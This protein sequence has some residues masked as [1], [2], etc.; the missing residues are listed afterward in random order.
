MSFMSIFPSSF[1]SSQGSYPPEP[2]V[3]L[4]IGAAADNAAVKHAMVK[5]AITNLLFIN[6]FTF[7]FPLQKSLENYSRRLI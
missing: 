1:T 2:E 7:P 3:L 6:D 5:T 4:L